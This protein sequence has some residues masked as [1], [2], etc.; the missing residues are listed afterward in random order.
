MDGLGKRVTFLKR[1]TGRHRAK[2]ATASL[3]SRIFPFQDGNP[4]T[5]VVDSRT[6]PR[7]PRTA[8]ACTPQLGLLIVTA[9]L[10]A[11]HGAA[12]PLG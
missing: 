10:A 2:R 11:R 8:P 5:A 3:F 12:R 9:A 4:S 1:T 6:P 7:P